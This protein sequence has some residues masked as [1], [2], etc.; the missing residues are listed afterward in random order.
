M[1]GHDKVSPPSPKRLRSTKDIENPS[2]TS[3][4]ELWME[5]PFSEDSLKTPNSI[6]GTSTGWFVRESY[7]SLYDEILSD[8]NT[9]R[10]QIVNGTAGVGKSSFL[11]YVLARTRVK[12][13]S[14]LLHYH[15]TKEETAALTFFPGSGSPPQTILAT[16]PDYFATFRKWYAQ[17]DQEHS[18]F[19]VDGIASFSNEAYTNVK[20]IVAKSP[21]CPLGWIEKSQ[22]VSDRWLSVW[23]EQE[24]LSYANYAGIAADVVR[25]NMLHL[26]GVGRYA[27][28]PGAAEAA[29][30]RAV[31]VAGAFDLYK[32]V[33]TGLTAKFD[34]QKVVDRLVHRHPPAGG[35]GLSNVK[36]T[37]ASE[38]VA[39]RVAMC[40]ALEN[41]IETKSLLAK[42]EAVGP[43]GGMRGVLFEAYAAR[44]IAEGGNFMVRRLGTG[45]ESTLWLQPREILQKNSKQLS[46]E[47]YPL[48]E[49]MDKVVWPNPDYNMPAI[50]TFMC[51]EMS[52]IAHQMT[53][54]TSHTLDI[55][56]CKAFL[57]YFDAI[58]KEINPSAAKPSLYNLYF[59]VPAHV[60]SQFS[61]S[62][63]SLTGQ[64][65]VVLRNKDAATTSSRISQ[66]VMKVE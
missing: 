65:G 10:I 23:S 27:F 8:A 6:F 9:H 57:R 43:A 36:V 61:K 32:L 11:L 48:S 47:T 7:I 30:I 33:T 40:L 38:F 12:Q 31:A 19:L 17:I 28:L 16:H 13:K 3:F 46:K 44:K 26:G 45:E 42:F 58:V 55:G 22:N 21:S 63:Q 14:V 59:T 1:S 15:R 60:Y 34:N 54:S 2:L 41:Q 51:H 29:A 24:L 18:F 49:I 20:Y 62:N 5:G 35:L 64:N 4:D 50:D 53:V 37:F 56:G 39:T 25:E 52:L 66:W